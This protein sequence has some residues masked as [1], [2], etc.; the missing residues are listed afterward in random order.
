MLK[1]EYLMMSKKAIAYAIMELTITLQ[2]AS[3]YPNL[4]L[5]KTKQNQQQ[6]KNKG[7]DKWNNNSE[8]HF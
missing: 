8:S 5:N 3:K 6:Q 7:S 2:W 1:V 4:W